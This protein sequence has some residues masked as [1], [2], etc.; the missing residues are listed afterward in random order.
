[1]SDPEVREKRTILLVEQHVRGFHVAVHDSRRMCR[2]ERAGHCIQDAQNLDRVM[3]RAAE[4]LQ[5]PCAGNVVHGQELDA[6]VRIEGEI[7]D[8]EHVGMAKAR[9]GSRFPLEQQQDRLF[10]RQLGLQDFDRYIALQRGL[11]SAVDLAEA[12]GGGQQLLDDERA[13]LE[14]HAVAENRHVNPGIASCVIVRA[15]T[16]LSAPWRNWL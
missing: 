14:G 15:T 8:W 3:R 1:V 13:I 12:A 2:V 6:H 10:L 11:E 9:R 7:D 5:G 4:D 16:Q